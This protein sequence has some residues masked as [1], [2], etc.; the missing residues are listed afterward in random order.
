MTAAIV[1][2]MLS[3]RWKALINRNRDKPET[4]SY[5]ISAPQAYVLVKDTL[6]TFQSGE[7]KWQIQYCDPEALSIMAIS[8]WR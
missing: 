2:F 4:F 5:K 3:Q 6:E 7:R 8:E 1:A